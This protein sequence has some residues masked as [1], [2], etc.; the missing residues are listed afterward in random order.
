[1]AKYP[2]LE[3]LGKV[4]DQRQAV[5]EFLDWLYAAR[6]VFLARYDGE[7]LKYYSY[8]TESLVAEFFELDLK[9][10]DLERRAM[11]KAIR[12]EEN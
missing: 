6:G 2:E 11:L 9:K 1:M 8:S 4:Q 10:I 5:E 3:K 12:E 7:E